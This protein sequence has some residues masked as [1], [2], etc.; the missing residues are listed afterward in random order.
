MTAIAENSTR[1]NG[2]GGSPRGRRDPEVTSIRPKS[3][4]RPP[5]VEYLGLLDEGGDL[6]RS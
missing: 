1:Y 3:A 2:S 5:V 6:H 4:P